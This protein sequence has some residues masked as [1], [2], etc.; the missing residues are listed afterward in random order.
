MDDW[1]FGIWVVPTVLRALCWVTAEDFESQS[2]MGKAIHPFL[3][4]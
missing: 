3:V 2:A 1:G 4:V